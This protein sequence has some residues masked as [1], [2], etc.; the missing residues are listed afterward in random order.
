M[1]VLISKLFG[2]DMVRTYIRDDSKIRTA[3]PNFVNKYS[4]SFSENYIP[5]SCS[6]RKDQRLREQKET[7]EKARTTDASTETQL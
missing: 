2:I 7:Q 4:I 1:K 5:Q 3:A 6:V